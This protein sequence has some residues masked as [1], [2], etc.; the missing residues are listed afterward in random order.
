MTDIVKRL[1]SLNAD[2]LYEE[3]ADEIEQLRETLLKLRASLLVA[4]S[5]CRSYWEWEYGDG[6]TDPSLLVAWRKD[7]ETRTL[8]RESNHD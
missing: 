8:P 7:Y 4:D 3:A 6:E 5:A 1:R 2:F